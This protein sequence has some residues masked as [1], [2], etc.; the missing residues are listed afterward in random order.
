MSFLQG[1]SLETYLRMARK[2]Q[3]DEN[4]QLDEKVVHTVAD[5][6]FKSDYNYKTFVARQ[7]VHYL[8]GF[9]EGFSISALHATVVKY[10]YSDYE[11]KPYLDIDIDR[12][13]AQISFG[14]RHYLTCPN[15]N[16]ANIFISCVFSG[17]FPVSLEMKINLPEMKSPPP[18]STFDGTRMILKRDDKIVYSSNAVIAVVRFSRP[19]NWEVSDD[20]RYNVLVITQAG[21]TLKTYT[22]DENLFFDGVKPLHPGNKSIFYGQ[23]YHELVLNFEF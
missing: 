8:F 16:L 22:V 15:Q 12:V 7:I 18:G 6:A 1:K 9:M 14:V 3:L 10:L 19:M 17:R 23:I 13:I 5:H 20:Y 2:S 4:S 21:E 11:L